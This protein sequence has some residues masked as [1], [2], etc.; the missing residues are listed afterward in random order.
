MQTL[1]KRVKNKKGFTLI[2]LIVVIVI[3]GILAA[4]AIPSLAGFQRTAKYKADIA[5]AKTIATA[6]QT[7]MVDNSVA[8]VNLTNLGSYFAGASPTPALGSG[9]FAITAS[10]GTV[11]NVYIELGADNAYTPASDVLLWPAPATAPT[12][13]QLT[14]WGY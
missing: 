3:I 9:T 8:T 13:A 10:S 11:T 14:T 6:A 5:T 12:A 1:S 2:E 4:I 7:Y